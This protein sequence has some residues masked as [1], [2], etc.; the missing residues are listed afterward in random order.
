YVKTQI[1]TLYDGI[2]STTSC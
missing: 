1:V 2:V